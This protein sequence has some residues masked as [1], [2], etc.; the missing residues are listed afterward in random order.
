MNARPYCLVSGLLFLLVAIAH[1]YRVLG[2]YPVLVG[3]VSIPMWVS[4]V[5]IV[6]TPCLGVWALR[7]VGKQ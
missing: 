2:S 5:G 3:E 6:V 7:L 4:Y 1:L